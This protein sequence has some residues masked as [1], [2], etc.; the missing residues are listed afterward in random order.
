MELREFNMKVKVFNDII[1]VFKSDDYAKK[2][3]SFQTK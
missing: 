3:G 2:N 1:F